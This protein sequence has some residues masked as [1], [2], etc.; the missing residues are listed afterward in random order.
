[1]LKYDTG[2]MSESEQTADPAAH[3]SSRGVSW[4]LL[5]GTALGV[6][7]IG[8]QD[9]PNGLWTDEAVNGYYSYCLLET[10]RD[11]TGDF[12]PLFS[13]SMAGTRAAVRRTGAYI[14][15]PSTTSTV[16]TDPVT[17]SP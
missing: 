13:R 3:G 1:M 12:L 2:R 9:N 11:P 15:A 14:T 10:G 8:L 7:T 5:L 16:A 17:A 4:L 6:R